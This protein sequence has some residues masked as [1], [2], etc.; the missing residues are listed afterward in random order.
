MFGPRE[1]VQ[2]YAK[3]H[4]ILKLVDELVNELLQHKPCDPLAHLACYIDGLRGAAPATDVEKNK[5]AAEGS[6]AACAEVSHPSSTSSSLEAALGTLWDACRPNHATFK[7]RFEEDVSQGLRDVLATVFAK[8]GKAK[9]QAARVQEA[10]DTPVETQ[11]KFDASPDVTQA[12]AGQSVQLVDPYSAEYRPTQSVS[13]VVDGLADWFG[14]GRKL[15][16]RSA[17]DRVKHNC[18]FMQHK[19][20]YGEVAEVVVPLFI[21]S[22]AVMTEYTWAFWVASDGH[23]RWTPF[24][25]AH[26][27]VLE[28]DFLAHCTKD[29]T[30]LC[31]EDED[32]T[33]PRGL[34]LAPLN[35]TIAD[36]RRALARVA[37]DTKGAGTI[38]SRQPASAAF[39]LPTQ[40]QVVFCD[41]R[42]VGGSSSEGDERGRGF[43]GK[44]DGV[45]AGWEGLTVFVSTPFLEGCKCRGDTT[46]NTT[47]TATA[48]TDTTKDVAKE[49]YIA[50]YKLADVRAEY[51]DA[52]TQGTA[53]A[54]TL[55]SLKKRVALHPYSDSVAW[56]PAPSCIFEGLH[57]ATADVQHTQ[58]MSVSL[59]RLPP[60]GVLEY[61]Q[62]RRTCEHLEIAEGGLHYLRSEDVFACRA[63]EEKVLLAGRKQK[64][65]ETETE[66]ATA[67]VRCD[68]SCFFCAVGALKDRCV[69]EKN[70]QQYDKGCKEDLDA[71]TTKHTQDYSPFQALVAHKVAIAVR[72]APEGQAPTPLTIL[73]A[74]DIQAVY[75]SSAGV[76]DWTHVEP[77]HASLS[78]KNKFIAV[79]G[80]DGPPCVLYKSCCE[81][82]DQPYYV[83]NA[84]M[85]DAQNKAHKTQI[86]VTRKDKTSEVFCA[87]SVASL[88]KGMGTLREVAHK[89][90][91]LRTCLRNLIRLSHQT[92]FESETS[93]TSLW[94]TSR[95]I[96][97][98]KDDTLPPSDEDYL[99][100]VH[101]SG[102]GYYRYTARYDKEAPEYMEP[103]TVKVQMGDWVSGQ[104]RPL[105]FYVNEAMKKMS[106]VLSYRGW[107]CAPETEQKCYRGLGNARLPPELYATGNVVVW[108]AFSSTSTDQG[109]SQFYAS[110]ASGMTAS[111]FIV[112]GSSCRL[113]APW[114]RFGREEE[115]LFPL[116]SMFKVDSMLTE[117]QQSIL[118]KKDFQLFEISEVDELSM[119]KIR[120]RCSLAS[121]QTKEIARVVF[122][123]V[124]ALDS[125]NGV[126][127]LSLKSASE[128]CVDAKWVYTVVVNFDALQ[129]S[130]VMTNNSTKL[131]TGNVADSWNSFVSQAHKRNRFTHDCP[132]VIFDQ[133]SEE[134]RQVLNAVSLVLGLRHSKALTFVEVTCH[135][136]PS[137]A[138]DARSLQEENACSGYYQLKAMNPTE[139][140]EVS[141]EMRRED[142]QEGYAFG[143]SGAVLLHQIIAKQVHLVRI[144]IRNNGVGVKGAEL[145]LQAL[146]VN[147]HV[148]QLSICEQK[149]KPLQARDTH[150]CDA[151]DGDELHLGELAAQRMMHIQQV[152]NI[153][154]AHNRGTIVSSTFS[155]LGDT[156][157]QCATE[158]L[159]DVDVVDMAFSDLFDTRQREAV[160]FIR[161]LQEEVDA[162]QHAAQQQ[163]SA[164]NRTYPKLPG[165]LVAAAR[166]C[167]PC[168]IELLLD[169]HCDPFETDAFG[170]TPQLKM[171]RRLNRGTDTHVIHS[172]L[173]D[174]LVQRLHVCLDRLQPAVFRYDEPLWKAKNFALEVMR[175]AD[176]RDH[177]SLANELIHNVRISY[178]AV[179]GHEAATLCASSYSTNVW[180]IMQDTLDACKKCPVL[181]VLQCPLGRQDASLFCLKVF[182]SRGNELFPIVQATDEMYAMIGTLCVRSTGRKK[183]Q[184]DDPYQSFA[185]FCSNARWNKHIN[186]NW[187][188][189]AE[190]AK[191]PRRMDKNGI[192][193]F[194]HEVA[195]QDTEPWSDMREVDVFST[196][197]RLYE[198][199]YVT[200]QQYL[201]K[202]WS[203]AELEPKQI[204]RQNRGGY[205]V[206]KHDWDADMEGGAWEDGKKEETMPML[207]TLVEQLRQPSLNLYDPTVFG[208]RI[209]MEKSRAQ[210]RTWSRLWGAVNAVLVTS[211]EKERVLFRKVENVTDTVLL[212]HL[213]LKRGELYCQPDIT[214]WDVERRYRNRALGDHNDSG[215]NTARTKVE[216]NDNSGRLWEASE[217]RWTG[218]G[219]EEAAYEGE[220]CY[221][222]EFKDKC[223]QAHKQARKERGEVVDFDLN[224]ILRWEDAKPEDPFLT[225]A[226]GE[227][228]EVETSGCSSMT[229]ILF[230][231]RGKMHGECV[232]LL[233]DA[234]DFL[235]PA[236]EMFVVEDVQA[237]GACLHVSLVSRG[238]LLRTDRELRAWCS[239]MQNTGLDSVWSKNGD[240]TDECLRPESKT[241][242]DDTL[243]KQSFLSTDECDVFFSRKSQMLHVTER[244][245]ILG[246][247]VKVI[248]PVNAFAFHRIQG[249]NGQMTN[250]LGCTLPEALPTTYRPGKTF[251][252]GLNRKKRP[253]GDH[254]AEGMRRT[255]DD[256]LAHIPD[257]ELAKD[258][259]KDMDV[260]DVVTVSGASI[261]AYHDEHTD[262]DAFFKTIVK[263]SDTP[264]QCP[265]PVS[266]VYGGKEFRIT[267]GEVQ[268][269]LKTTTIVTSPSL[270]LR[271]VQCLIGSFTSAKRRVLF[272]NVFR[273]TSLLSID[274]HWEHAIIVVR[275]AAMDALKFSEIRQRQ[276]RELGTRDNTDVNSGKL[277]RNLV[278]SEI[279][280]QILAYLD[281]ELDDDGAEP[282][283]V[284][285]ANFTSWMDTVQAEPAQYGF[286][287]KAHARLTL[288]KSMVELGTEMCVSQQGFSFTSGMDGEHNQLCEKTHHSIAILAAPVMDFCYERPTLCE[289][290]KYFVRVPRKGQQAQQGWAFFQEGKQREFVDR[291]KVLYTCI[292]ESARKQCVRNMCM[293]PMGLGVYTANLGPDLRF[294][295]AEMYFRAQFELL[296]EQDWGFENV[297]MLF[298]LA[299]HSGFAH[300]LLIRVRDTVLPGTPNVVDR[301][302]NFLAKALSQSSFALPS[303]T[304]K[305]VLA[306]LKCLYRHGTPHLEERTV[307]VWRLQQ[308]ST[309]VV[310]E[311]QHRCPQQRC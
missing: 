245:A 120:I 197:R 147:R 128:G 244:Q 232:G 92:C 155:D 5:L 32:L 37:E 224:M 68:D 55:A 187:S 27:V 303:N 117:D 43:A 150:T 230:S 39:E 131:C 104:V 203:T 97:D 18:T 258:W 184:A 266:D 70:Q 170:E 132:C 300:V 57:T 177:I 116:N 76:A 157:P 59:A 222:H 11:L 255:D 151:E 277:Y 228:V 45:F 133:S 108:S 146:R 207:P 165:A 189:L 311:V 26:A 283:E 216:F 299:S 159:Y 236:L 22:I 290:P 74:L 172:P 100:P 90:A 166:F 30:P 114:S 112:T 295:V 243:D 231:A 278:I 191:L 238:S 48:T 158:A 7:E 139:Q 254:T 219:G 308:R 138:K 96:I 181:N 220:L 10:K 121:A 107:R 47:D 180:C 289:A 242:D 140:W 239:S 94:Y 134:G 273:A 285:R 173:L 261:Q 284:T 34:P 246:D 276:A 215:D 185:E 161:L 153:R 89:H 227:Q 306:D 168:D 54:E 282:I 310:F 287:S 186:E 33:R 44:V 6:T 301:Q 298:C 50:R 274:E 209:E 126:L 3:Q 176:D 291:L 69:R 123:A 122:S 144:D 178:E 214:L 279:N 86:T 29:G 296:A 196:H 241:A 135:L 91:N 259:E 15:W 271:F 73:H 200:K 56:L 137:K 101:Y 130:P 21:Y 81:F 250:H 38:P 302:L 212:H 275:R 103:S 233:S 24:S 119:E 225:H 1:E 164:S 17:V 234:H 65:A 72:E 247:L 8:T 251:L 156:W 235:L 162:Q 9:G 292:F 87:R 62:S 281:G 183:Q 240:D 202:L 280:K 79:P 109:I 175:M 129:L 160:L 248:R 102:L 19:H 269:L 148:V 201:D 198:G 42:M 141:I 53:D 25:S 213:H 2:A 195:L 257:V 84:S 193:Y 23:G 221:E 192:Y 118:G 253:E 199:S 71:L 95:D 46:T 305:T 64:V 149:Q 152:I 163:D 210:L 294:Q 40:M 169:M 77:L 288:A 208:S 174:G 204:R 20:N 237:R 309:G 206:F 249:A 272:F 51:E 14:P 110:S 125:G 88:G 111:V 83:L 171:W 80:A 267:V 49:F 145:L 12:N 307:R 16:P 113:I 61:L 78:G 297:C 252:S 67:Y 190:E 217:R 58:T 82:A 142:G 106:P 223:M 13:E 194:E 99:D 36:A 93:G 182:C 105:L 179:V 60:P 4:S 265:P 98:K 211:M 226:P 124:S 28:K 154:C 264:G 31:G 35:S 205:F 218:R 270:P 167:D 229:T 286:T 262:E 136:K 75:W 256:Q 52:H 115:W 143:P 188:S 293:L 263:G 63:R 66:A 268:Q 85:R 260:N 127:D 304:F 41:G